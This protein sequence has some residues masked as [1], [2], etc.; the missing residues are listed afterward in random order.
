MVA[1]QSTHSGRRVHSACCSAVPS[2]QTKGPAE[3]TCSPAPHSKVISGVKKLISGAKGSQLTS[4]GMMTKKNYQRRPLPGMAISFCD[5]TV[6]NCL[7]RYC[8]DPRLTTA[9]IARPSS[10]SGTVVRQKNYWK[11]AERMSQNATEP[12]QRTNCVTGRDSPPHSASGAIEL[13]TKTATQ[14]PFEVCLNGPKTPR[15]C[16]S[17]SLHYLK[18]VSRHVLALCFFSTSCS[19]FTRAGFRAMF[20]VLVA[21]D[22]YCT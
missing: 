7:V 8:L 19:N 2:H 12:Q 13:R 4:F 5:T 11:P 16:F 10:R 3:P 1:T 17:S 18:Y 21:C 22:T 20:S 6:A 9:A 15:H 14:S